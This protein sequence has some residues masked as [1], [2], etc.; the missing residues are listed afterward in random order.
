MDH[1]TL[2]EL[3][4]AYALGVLDADEKRQI[5]ALLAED[6]EARQLLDEY[7]IVAESIA[8]T[9]PA[10]QPPSD[11]E[12]KLLFRAR[13]KRALRSYRLPLAAAAIFLGIIGVV[14]LFGQMS[15]EPAN[16]QVIYEEIIA[17]PAG[18]QLALVPDLSPDIAGQLVYLKDENKAVLRVSNVPPLDDG[19]IYQLWLVD[20]AGSSSGGLYRLT[21]ET[22][23]VQIAI[24]KPVPEYAR[25]G[26]SLEPESGSP[27]GD[28]PSGPRVFSIPIR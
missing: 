8:L 4:P 2:R 25:F 27:L 26:V 14:L 12:Q 21:E 24:T 18:M 23:Y 10:K 19:Q 7:R 11:F 17:D 1:E 9:A 5:E 15:S 28:Q 16:G 22:N 6:A 3:I 20:D 13:R